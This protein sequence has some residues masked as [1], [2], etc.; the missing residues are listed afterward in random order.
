MEKADEEVLKLCDD[1]RQ[2]CFDIHKFL[3]PGFLE[4]IYENA[5]KHRLRK[6]GYKVESQVKL[7]IFDEDG[8][9]IGE[10]F[11]DLIVDNFLIIE[12]KACKVLADEHIAQIFGYMRAS[13]IKHG[14][15]VNFGG[16]RFQVRKFA[17]TRK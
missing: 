8:T 16:E 2:T 3:G 5:L 9:L 12:I 6:N 13:R 17:K 7:E 11:T 10:H 1:I 15:L 4:K 14:L